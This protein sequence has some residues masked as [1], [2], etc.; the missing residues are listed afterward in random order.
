MSS[1]AA[2]PTVVTANSNSVS[3]PKV[4]AAAGQRV[5][6]EGFNLPASQSVA[7]P[8]G[9]KHETLII[10][11]S[12][13][14]AWGSMFNID[15]REKN[16]ILNN[17]TLQMAL[18]AI[19]AGTGYYNPAWFWVPRM[20]VC[21]NNVILDTLYGNQQFLLNQM[22]FDDQD[23]LSTNNAAGNYASV[24][25]RTGMVS[26]TSGNVFYINLQ[27]YFDQIKVHLLT[28]AH[29]IQL[30]VYVANFADC[31]TALTGAGTST[32][33]SCNAICKVT[34]LDGPS[35]AV[36]LNEMRLAPYHSVFHELHYLPVT[37]LTGIT[38]TNIVLSSLVG[39]V[40]AIVFTVR[41]TITGSG[42]Y[43][44]TQ[45]SSF[46]LLDGAS[47]NL[48]GGQAIPAALAANIL[49]RDWCKSS[50]NSETSFG[51]TNNSANFYMWS[52]S[53]DPVGALLGGQ[54]LTSRR[55]TGQENLQITFPTATTAQNTVDIY[56]FTESVIEQGVMDIR[57][58]SL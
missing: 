26:T 36:R 24:T 22:L 17:V 27:A 18:S 2:V 31:Y 53:A 12:S 9:L 21:Q 39:R 58:I 15:I 16:V 38:T 13:N 40:A 41:P 11:S 3:A 37:V 30:R 55:M 35:A 48:V 44:Y 46:A 57:K 4:A 52:F 28:D 42:A 47:T 29:A 32:I 19:S 14:P 23:R 49:N 1:A 43:T 34:R 6:A 5:R 33:T 20:E 10:P 50:Y 7:L 54:A 25:Q 45:L 56:A 8:S 51:S